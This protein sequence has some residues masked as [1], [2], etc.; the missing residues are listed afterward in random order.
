MRPTRG[1]VD[2]GEPSKQE[3]RQSKADML[4]WQ[5]VLY[6][7]Q[8]FCRFSAMCQARQSMQPVEELAGDAEPSSSSGGGGNGGDSGIEGR[9][10][11]SGGNSGTSSSGSGHFWATG[12]AAAAA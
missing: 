10:V 8:R 1:V 2:R 9:I 12:G 4:T 6:T 5:A 11:S 3:S 7:V